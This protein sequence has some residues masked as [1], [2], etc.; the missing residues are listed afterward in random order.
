MALKLALKI[1][2]KIFPTKSFILYIYILM[3]FAWLM[4]H[5]RTEYGTICGLVTTLWISVEFEVAES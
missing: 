1:S 4:V 3:L 2:F 5:N